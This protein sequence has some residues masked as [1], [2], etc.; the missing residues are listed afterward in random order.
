VAVLLDGS[1]G[2]FLLQRRPKEGLLASLWELPSADL[3][4]NTGP[5]DAARWLA[6]GADLTFCGTVE[7]RFS[8]RHWVIQVFRGR[9]RL[10]STVEAAEGEAD[11]L[12]VG[13]SDLDQLGIP[14]V[15]RKTIDCALQAAGTRA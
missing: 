13:R 11:Q 2:R 8:H 6:T 7:H 1:D 10:P 9:L 15:T 3:G 4:K 12:R 14:T 5:E